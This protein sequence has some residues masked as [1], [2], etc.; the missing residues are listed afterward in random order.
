[1]VNICVIGSSTAW[2]P[3]VVTDLMCTFDEQ[4]EFR[5]VDIN[6][7]A[8]DLAA[9]FGQVANK[10]HHRN[11]RFI[12]L[13]DRRKGLDGA[14]AVIITVATGGLN[15]MEQDLAIPEKYGIHTTVG[16][17]C[18]PGGWSRCIRNIPVFMDFAADCQDMC[19]R[20]FIANYSNPMAALTATLSQCCDNPVAGLCHAYFETKDVIQKIFRL[21][22]W[23]QLSLSIA[24]MNHFTWVVD[25]SVGRDDG[26]TLL[27]ERL[28]TGSLRDLLPRESEDEI[29]YKSKHELCIELFDAFGYLPYPADRHTS[30]FVSFVIT[31]TGDH[32]ERYHAE[33]DDLDYEIIRYCNVRRTSIDHRRGGMVKRE[34]R[35]HDLI[36][37]KAKM[38]EKTRETSAKMIRSYLDNKPFVESANTINIGQIP[39]LPLGACVETLSVIDG[40]GVR[41]LTVANVPE[42][43]LEVMRPQAICQK[44]ITQGTI[45]RNKDLLVQALYR[46]PQCAHLNPRQVRA[47]AEEL[48]EAN[49]QFVT[50]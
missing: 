46:D 42:H 10:H 19:P 31:G 9:E 7:R 16:D 49:K 28:G 43:L 37:G 5:L 25:F 44:W 2:I 21:P 48:F 26:Y 47:M 12:P 23:S 32:P 4:I 35:M 40:L 50:F 34:Q 36:A 20:A 18:G 3:G 13:T 38:P 1:M 8:A 33:L 17:T 14:D 6:P 45:E 15:A 41:P 22:D 27:R 39:G 11:D 30:E 29:G 24:G